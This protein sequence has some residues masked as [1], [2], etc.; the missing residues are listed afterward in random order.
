VIRT[1]KPNIPAAMNF[2]FP[3]SKH[4]KRFIGISSLSQDRR[5]YHR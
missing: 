1:A 5:L 2:I 4:V 3:A